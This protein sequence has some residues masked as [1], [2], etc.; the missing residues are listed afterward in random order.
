[1]S[2]LKTVSLPPELTYRGLNYSNNQL[3][4]SIKHYGDNLSN[5]FDWV[6]Q[7]NW[8][9]YIRKDNKTSAN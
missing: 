8:Q 9:T 1:M 4:D 5:Y 7:F 3:A 2:H 6:I